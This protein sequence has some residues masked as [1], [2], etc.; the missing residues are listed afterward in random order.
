MTQ[1]M[2][3]FKPD[4]MRNGFFTVLPFVGGVPETP[5]WRMQAAAVTTLT[6]DEAKE[7]YAR[8]EG[9]NFYD[10]LIRFTLGGWV[11]VSVWSALQALRQCKEA[12]CIGREKVDAVRRLLHCEVPAVTG[13]MNAIH[14]SDGP[15]AAEREVAWAKRIILSR[16]RE[17]T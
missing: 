8:H 3:M 11:C 15:E 9:K 5:E 14:G 16:I 13:P 6:E 10:G 17:L 4:T 2:L 7:L 12:W 1:T